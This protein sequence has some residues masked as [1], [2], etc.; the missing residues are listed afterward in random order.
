MKTYTKTI[1][2]PKLVIGYD[3]NADTPRN[4]CNLSILI[5]RNGLGDDDKYLNRELRGTQ[6]KVG[7]TEDH[8]EL[9]KEIVEKHLGSKVI[10]ADFIS[11][12]EH[13]SVDY[14][15]GQSSGWDYSNMGF[16]F[17]TEDSLRKI[18]CSKENIK[19]IVENEIKTFS[20]W[21]NGD[22]YQ[23]TL[24]DDEGNEEDSMGSIYD[25]EEIREYLPEEWADEDLQQYIKYD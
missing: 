24:Y 17:V 19:E 22:V 18:G 1:E 2:K 21:A 12:Y 15:V 23:F 9:M 7:C 25:L 11:K 20:K 5:I 4:W 8:L 13:S 14:F 16:V 10:Y 3:I 6:H